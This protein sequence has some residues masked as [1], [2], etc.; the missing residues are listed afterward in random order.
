MIEDIGRNLAQSALVLLIALTAYAGSYRLLPDAARSLR[1]SAAFVGALW[2][3]TALFF[4]LTA[5]GLFFAPYA[6][7]AALLCSLPA[8]RMLPR[9]PIAA[10]IGALRSALH[11]LLRHRVARWVLLLVALVIGAR[12]LRGL[13]APP[14][15]WDSLTYHLPRAVGWLNA[16]NLEPQ[17]APDA[18]RYY[19]YYPL[20]GDSVWAWAMLCTRTTTW[21]APINALIWLAIVLGA[22]SCA[23]LL[24]APRPS[25][26]IAALVVAMTPAVSNFFSACYVNNLALACF[27]CGAALLGQACTDRRALSAAIAIAG[28]ALATATQISY[29]PAVLGAALLLLIYRRQHSLSATLAA[30]IIPAAIGLLGYVRAWIETGNPLYPLGVSVSGHQLL[31][32]NAELAQLLKARLLPH[33]ISDWKQL[34]WSLTIAPGTGLEHLN[35]G[36]TALLLLP[37]AIA[38]AIGRLRRPDQRALLLLLFGSSLALLWGYFSP[39]MLAQRVFWHEISGRFLCALTATVTMLAAAGSASTHRRGLLLG[40]LAINTALSVPL[41]ISDADLAAIVAIAPWLLLAAVATLLARLAWRRL[42]SKRRRPLA[43]LAALIVV[44]LFF[45]ALTAQRQL[46]RYPIYRASRRL[47]PKLTPWKLSYE[48]HP[49][50]PPYNASIAVAEHFD[51]PKRSLRIALVAG[52]DGIGHNWVRQ[53]FYGSRLQNQVIY[54]PPSESGKLIDYRQHQALQRQAS[55]PAWLKR[56]IDARVDRVASLEPQSF[57]DRWMREQPR[58]FVPVAS[59]P[60]GWAHGY[61]F[62]PQ[63]AQRWLRWH[64]DKKLR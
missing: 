6:L 45:V 43:L 64:H 63:G 40:A 14:L 41:G 49:N 28:L 55:F 11:S 48:I 62:R 18:W 19:E 35:L 56:L 53:P 16:G 7:S 51:R 25:A 50:W 33:A 34:L 24:R 54:V 5:L 32:G 42:G 46:H 2:L 17:L 22:Y 39:N 61:R 20:V 38:P 4:L 3:L 23:R 15:A 27:L 26:G 52:F 31:A 59:G 57:E 10:D 8:W 9:L 13:V 29:G 60:L 58:I 36:P 1:W 37:L 44:A 30:L 21:L 47:L 12:F